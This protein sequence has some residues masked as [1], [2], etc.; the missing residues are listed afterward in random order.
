MSGGNRDSKAE[1]IT[2]HAEQVRLVR[3]LRA[4]GWLV[5][6]TANGASMAAHTRSRQSAAGLARGLPDL[7]V[8]DAPKGY[9]GVAIE[10]K[11]A[12]GGKASPEQK[13]WIGWLAARGWLAFVAHGA[14]EAIERI[15]QEETRH[16]RCGGDGEVGP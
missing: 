13:R 4:R 15:E 7:L 5:S 1:G 12:A 2:E 14:D 6:A 3:W 10:L 8:F 16:E 11:R 9:V